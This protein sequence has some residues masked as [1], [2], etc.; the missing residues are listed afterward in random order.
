MEASKPLFYELYQGNSVL[1]FTELSAF[2]IVILTIYGETSV[3]ALDKPRI[4]V[5]FLTLIF[6][7]LLSCAR[8][9]TNTLLHKAN[10]ELHAVILWFYPFLSL[11][12]SN[13]FVLFLFIAPTAFSTRVFWVQM[14][15]TNARTSTALFILPLL[16]FASYLI[17]CF[18]LATWRY[19]KLSMV[20]DVQDLVTLKQKVAHLE[21]LSFR[22]RKF[23]SSA[24]V[25]IFFVLLLIGCYVVFCRPEVVLFY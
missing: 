18:L 7:I 14:L 16:A 25:F 23:N 17:F 22:A 21:K 13:L 20:L 11:T 15:E 24:F 9:F 4:F 6:S 2:T 8:F 10:L 19:L 1:T 3:L 12:F 5:I